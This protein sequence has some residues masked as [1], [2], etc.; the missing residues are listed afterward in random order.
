MLPQGC[1]R[2]HSLS[3]E[4]KELQYKGI[5]ILDFRN[6]SLLNPSL[7]LFLECYLSLKVSWQVG[8]AHISILLHRKKGQYMVHAY[9]EIDIKIFQTLL[10]KNISLEESFLCTIAFYFLSK[11]LHWLGHA[12]KLLRPEGIFRD[13]CV[14]DQGSTGW[15]KRRRCWR[16]GAVEAIPTLAQAIRGPV[17]IESL[18]ININTDHSQSALFIMMCQQSSKSQ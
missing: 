9:P 15:G 10:C 1:K 13:H 6:N 14:R 7:V 12:I 8:S 16:D 18:K 4:S 5:L 2:K 3:S 17:C 11:Y